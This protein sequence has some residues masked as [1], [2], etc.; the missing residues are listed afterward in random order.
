MFFRHSYKLGV[1]A[2]DKTRRRSYAI[3]QFLQEQRLQSEV[4]S[5]GSS[6]VI[7]GAFDLV[8]LE[9]F[10]HQPAVCPA[11]EGKGLSGFGQAEYLIKRGRK[12]PYA[13]AVGADESAV[14]I[15]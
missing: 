5:P 6:D 15:K 10:L 3:L 12:G 14:D 7:L 11:G 8:L 9:H 13:R 1:S 4:H 2:F